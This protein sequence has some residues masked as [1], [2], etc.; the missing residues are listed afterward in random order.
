MEKFI[1]NNI[2]NTL[3]IKLLQ[4]KYGNKNGSKI[5]RLQAT[6]VIMQKETNL[7]KAT[8]ELHDASVT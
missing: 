2:Y 5:W 3:I 7:K 8:R 6:Y 4:N 1:N